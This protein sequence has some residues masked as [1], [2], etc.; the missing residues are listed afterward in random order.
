MLEAFA[1]FAGDM[2]GTV[3]SVEARYRKKL[4]QQDNGHIGIPEVQFVSNVRTHS[5]ECAASL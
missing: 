5:A 4:S 2:N 1:G 3:P